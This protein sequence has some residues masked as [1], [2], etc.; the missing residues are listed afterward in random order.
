MPIPKNY[1]L[2]LDNVNLILHMSQSN[3]NLALQFSTV[4][5]PG[6]QVALLLCH[7]H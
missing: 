7:Q 1:S 2:L 5:I 4:I 3:P 6:F